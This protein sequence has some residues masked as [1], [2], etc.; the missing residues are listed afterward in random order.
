M[1]TVSA[2]CDRC[3]LDAPSADDWQ[4]CYGHRLLL[5]ETFADFHRF[6]AAC[7][8]RQARLQGNP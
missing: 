5:L 4:T 2:F 8:V 6:T 7:I 1:P 3:T